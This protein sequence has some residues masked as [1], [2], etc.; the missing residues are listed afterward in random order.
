MHA[1]HRHDIAMQ[2]P[3]EVSLRKQ[4]RRALQTLTRVVGPQIPRNDFVRPGTASATSG[5]S[6][7]ASVLVPVAT[8]QPRIPSHR[9]LHTLQEIQQGG[10]T[11]RCSTENRVTRTWQQVAPLYPEA[12][13]R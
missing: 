11:T 10:T 13:V 9:Q 12:I 8:L 2:L 3:I 4:R 6:C 5:L 7:R 1:V